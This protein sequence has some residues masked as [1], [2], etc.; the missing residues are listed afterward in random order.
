MPQKPWTPEEDEI[1][2][3]RGAALTPDEI[4]LLL[5][6]RT[7]RSVA[8]KKSRLG[9]RCGATALD[10]VFRC[11]SEAG[12]I[13]DRTLT[14]DAL[15]P[16]VQQVIIGGLLGDGGIRKAA[17]EGRRGFS[18]GVTHCPKQADYALWKLTMLAPLHPSRFV[19]VNGCVR[20]FTASHALFGE[21]RRV[22]YADKGRKHKAPLEWISRLDIL[23]FLIWWL[24][25]GHRGRKNGVPHNYGRISVAR[26][27]LEHAKAVAGALSER[28]GAPI[29]ARESKWKG[30]HARHLIFNSEAF[31]ILKPR[32]QAT[33]K[34]HG[35]PECMAY[36]VFP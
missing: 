3:Q 29:F 5:P 25:D 28:F 21:L 20:G 26:L 1:I 7:H 16:K 13:L 17:R 19:D 33:F 35:L 32:W 14:F 6:G 34:E 30:T 22:F 18:F 9:V 10:R 36:K 15:D 31:P 23:G 24:D 2:R 4:G 12:G 11:M 27:P 8:N